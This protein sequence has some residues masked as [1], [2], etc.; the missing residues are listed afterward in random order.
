MTLR[1]YG[2]PTGSLGEV[3]GLEPEALNN[4][5]TTVALKNTEKRS[6]NNID[7]SMAMVVYNG[8]EVKEVIDGLHSLGLKRNVAEDWESG[9]L[10]RRKACREGTGPLADI[11]NYANNLKKV[12]AKI[13]QSDRRKKMMDVEVCPG[14]IETDDRP[15]EDVSEF[16]FVL[17]V[18]GG[19]RKV[20][21][22]EGGGGGH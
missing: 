8:N 15:M 20:M 5:C 16:D 2:R 13:R 4:Q 14:E 19:K 1:E 10:K 6:V 17:K 9:K 18:R 12:K 11:S 7:D 22:A 21:E 3:A